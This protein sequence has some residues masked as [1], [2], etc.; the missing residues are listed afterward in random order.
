MTNLQFNRKNLEKNIRQ[1]VKTTIH[2]N[3]ENQK[4]SKI[5][6]IFFQQEKAFQLRFK[7]VI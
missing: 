1:K 5:Y 6:I 2:Q 4:N 7:G 3:P